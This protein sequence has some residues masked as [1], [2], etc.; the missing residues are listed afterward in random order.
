MESG[1]VE[2]LLVVED[3]RAV[4]RAIARFLRRRGY[5]VS[6]AHSRAAALSRRG[7]F[8]CGVFDVDLPDGSGIELAKEL[9]ESSRVDR[10]VFFSASPRSGV[11]QRAER[12]GTFVHKAEG[13]A[14][15]GEAVAAVLGVSKAVGHR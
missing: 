15:L 8:T 5:S 13:V 7:E 6:V 14:E 12:L 9:L 11:A 1:T 3:D 10:A 2:R 4:A